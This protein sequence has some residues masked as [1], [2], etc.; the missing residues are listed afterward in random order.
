M[1]RSKGTLVR[2]EKVFGVRETNTWREETEEVN[3]ECN[4]RSAVFLLFGRL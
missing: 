1:G 4:Y 2:G 3:W